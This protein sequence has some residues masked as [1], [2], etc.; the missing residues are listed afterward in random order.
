MIIK[1]EDAPNIKNLKIDI[2]FDENGEMTQEIVLDEKMKA[3]IKKTHSYADEEL[4]L[5]DD[6]TINTEKVDLPEIPT[7]NRDVN[8]ADGMKDAEY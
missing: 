1:I 3:E 8:V 2:S 7:V 6:F 5:D 4:N